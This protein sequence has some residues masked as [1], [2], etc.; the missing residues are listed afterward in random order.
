[1]R[2]KAKA[3]SKITKDQREQVEKIIQACIEEEWKEAESGIPE[4]VEDYIELVVQ[5]LRDSMTI[6]V[7]EETK[8]EFEKRAAEIRKECMAEFRANPA[9]FLADNDNLLS[10]VA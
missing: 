5:D 7:T 3:K 9:R 10:A 6:E 2:K 8:Q 1:M 4:A